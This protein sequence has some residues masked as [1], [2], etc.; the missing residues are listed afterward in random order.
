MAKADLKA[1]VRPE[2]KIFTGN[3]LAIDMV[4]YGSDYL[5]G[6]STFDPAAFA[7]RDRLWEEGDSRFYQL[8]DLLQYLGEFAF[9]APTPAYKHSA[10]QFLH[11]RGWIETD[12][13][14]PNAPERPESDKEILALISDRLKA[15]VDWVEADLKAS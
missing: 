11:L 6:L 10:A 5:L 1:E 4:M 14:H 12:R 13:T 8:N 7:L 9:R 2:F 3:D 15:Y